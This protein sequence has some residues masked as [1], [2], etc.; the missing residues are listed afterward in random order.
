MKCVRC[1]YC[2]HWYNVII[3]DDSEKGINE[4]NLKFKEGDGTR[5]QHLQG[6]EPGE[7]SCDLHDKEWY[8]ETP[9]Y[10]FTQIERNPDTPCRVGAYKMK[11]WRTRMYIQNENARTWYGDTE[12]DT[13]QYAYG[14]FL[15]LCSRDGCPEKD[16]RAAIF[17]G[18]QMEQLGHFMMAN[19]QITEGE[20]PIVLSGGYGSDG[21][22]LRLE[23]N[24]KLW[25]YM[26][27]LPM[28][29][30]EAWAHGGGWNSVG[31]EGFA[32]Q[33]WARE[34]F[35]RL[36]VV[37]VCQLKH[38]E[39]NDAF[40][41][42]GETVVRVIDHDP[43][44]DQRIVIVKELGDMTLAHDLEDQKQIYADFRNKLKLEE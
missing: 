27:Q 7:Y 34:N 4:D 20:K 17:P 30:Y 31:A 35:D 8:F 42:P 6:T 41:S 40:N 3:V 37:A 11:R 22:L 9:C 44:N 2:C 23:G 10:D 12:E 13:S 26:L 32:M 28:S 43:G 38:L 36:C 24:E 18:V 15:V 21:L 29:L 1:G 25:D 5:C 19:I 39:L 16:V 33:Q 14:D